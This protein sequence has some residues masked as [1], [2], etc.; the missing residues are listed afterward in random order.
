M[1]T[2]LIEKTIRGINP[3]ELQRV[4]SREPSGPPIDSMEQMNHFYFTGMRISETEERL[5]PSFLIC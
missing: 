3:D 4:L 5:L 1:Q 2:E